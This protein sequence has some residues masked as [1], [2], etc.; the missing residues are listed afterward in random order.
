VKVGRPA[1][2]DPKGSHHSR[3]SSQQ[4]RSG[5]GLATCATPY[6]RK[7]KMAQLS[8]YLKFNGNCRQALEFYKS[9]VGGQLILQT[10]GESPAAG[11]FPPAMK[12]KLLHGSLAKDNLTIFGS[13]VAGAE[14][15]QGNNVF[16]CLVCKSKEEIETL[17]SKLSQ[18][19]KVKTPPKHEFFGTYGDL[20]DKFGINWMFQSA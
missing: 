4:L 1:M 20:V 7:T 12:D 13:D 18:G 5:G 17:F 19:G 6:R 10:I 11:H 9:V 14:L 15:T 8:P 16:L 3:S 2:A